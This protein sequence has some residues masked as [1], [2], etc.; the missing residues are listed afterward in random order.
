MMEKQGKTK[1]NFWK[2]KRMVDLHLY[3]TFVRCHLLLSQSMFHNCPLFVKPRCH[4]STFWALN[5]C[6]TNA[7]SFL[8]I[9]VIINMWLCLKLLISLKALPFFSCPLFPP[10]FT[11]FLLEQN[12]KI[13]VATYFLKPSNFENMKCN[14]KPFWNRPWD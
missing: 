11:P 7:C 9:D 6:A 10:P 3:M 1:I 2:K 12:L 8:S 5:I 13:K 14:L 4:H